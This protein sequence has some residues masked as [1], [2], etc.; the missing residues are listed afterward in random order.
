MKTWRFDPDSFSRVGA[1]LGWLARWY[2]AAKCPCYQAATGGPRRSCDACRGTGYVYAD[3]VDG[4]FTMRADEKQRYP[5]EGEHTAGTLRIS[6]PAQLLDKSV[7]PFGYAVNPIYG[8]GENDLVILLQSKTRQ[9]DLLVKGDRDKLRYT[10]VESVIEVFALVD[11]EKTTYASPSD[12]SLSD[13][14]EIVWVEG[15]GPDA[16][17]QYSVQYWARPEYIVR[18]E[19]AAERIHGGDQL[20]KVLTLVLRDKVDVRA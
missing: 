5:M 17:T 2:R 10:L 12:Y 11:G 14:A 13:D 3:P 16:D 8:I 7:R 6:V 1:T 4:I 15:Q 20:P 9:H 18:E 19:L